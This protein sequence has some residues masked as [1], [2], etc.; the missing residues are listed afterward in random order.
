MDVKCIHSCSSVFYFFHVYVE[1]MVIPFGLH[2][3][4]HDC[5]LKLFDVR[6]L[7]RGRF[8]TIVYNIRIFFI[9][10]L[11][12]DEQMFDLEFVKRLVNGKRKGKR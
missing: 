7:L 2:S 5:L 3:T 6:P 9:E 11:P 1:L 4:I 8:E 10:M 12:D